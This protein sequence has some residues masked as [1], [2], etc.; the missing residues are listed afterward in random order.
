DPLLAVV[1]MA[2]CPVLYLLMALSRRS[3]RPRWAEV[4][5]AESAAVGV[6]HEVLAA[7]RTVK[8]FN[9]QEQ[10]TQRFVGRAGE[11]VTGTVRVVLVEGG[12]DLLVGLTIALGTAAVLVI[13]VR[14][15]QGGVLSLGSLLLVVGY[16]AQLYRPLEAISRQVTK[17][18]SYIASAERACA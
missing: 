16:L 15:V 11:L 9:R 3:V 12:F 5:A 13:G 10:E 6:V 8:S 1:A 18:Q 4:K 2:I 14:H 17:L 7:L